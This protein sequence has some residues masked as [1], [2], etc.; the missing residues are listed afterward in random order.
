MVDLR[1]R[2]QNARDRLRADA[3][4]AS[5]IERRKLLTQVRRGVDEEP[6]PLAAADRERRLGARS[7]PDAPAR[8]LADLTMAVPLRKPSAG[9]R[10][11]N[12]N[13][14]VAEESKTWPRQ[15]PKATSG[16]GSYR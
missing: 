5:L 3:V 8:G 1:V 13:A 10:P 15:A 12:V 4:D 6:R 14:H 2:Q 7:R 9:G 11:E 16:S